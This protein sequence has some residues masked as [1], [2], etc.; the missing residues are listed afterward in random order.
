MQRLKIKYNKFVNG[1]IG[2]RDSIVTEIL[3]GL[4]VRAKNLGHEDDFIQ[5]EV[6]YAAKFADAYIENKCKHLQEHPKGG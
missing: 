5:S 6:N 3:A 2:L 1:Q 4:A